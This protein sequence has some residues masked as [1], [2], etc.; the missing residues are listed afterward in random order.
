MGSSPD[1]IMMILSSKR[2]MLRLSKKLKTKN[3]KTNVK[4]T[5]RNGTQKEKKKEQTNKM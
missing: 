2:G 3:L 5:G 1:R 4:N